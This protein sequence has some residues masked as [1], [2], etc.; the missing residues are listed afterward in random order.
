MCKSNFFKRFFISVLV[1]W[2]RFRGKRIPAYPKGFKFVFQLLG[3]VSK[4]KQC[5]WS[6]CPNI[7]L[8]KEVHLINCWITERP[9]MYKS[10]KGYFNVF[11]VCAVVFIFIAWNLVSF[12]SLATLSNKI[13]G[14]G[15]LHFFLWVRSGKV[16]KLQNN[17]KSNAKR[18]QLADP[19]RRCF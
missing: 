12:L 18:K 13:N 17:K 9:G 11:T 1:N 10:S 2:F 8:T 7:N 15:R 5:L 19:D 14:L 16:R 6:Y 4:R 3:S